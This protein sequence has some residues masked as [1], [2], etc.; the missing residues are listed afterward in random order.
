ML[1]SPASFIINPFFLLK[2]TWGRFLL[3]EVQGPNIVMNTQSYCPLL[4]DV[5]SWLP[6]SGQ[7]F[8]LIGL[9][10]T[11]VYLVV[12]D[13]WVSQSSQPLC[14]SPESPPWLLLVSLYFLSFSEKLT[15]K[16]REAGS[17]IIYAWGLWTDNGFIS[18]YLPGSVIHRDRK[19]GLKWTCSSVPVP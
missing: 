16:H 1:L 19:Q 9:C 18:P 12:S 6:L 2:P 10:S 13:I 4:L 3:L 15:K 5:L 11:S 7:V 17:I 14:P 8:S